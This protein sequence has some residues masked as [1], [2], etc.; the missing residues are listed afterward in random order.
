MGC[1]L[2][3]RLI[4]LWTLYSMVDGSDRYRIFNFNVIS[5]NV[6]HIQSSEFEWKPSFFYEKTFI[7]KKKTKKENC[8][9]TIKIGR[10]SKEM[11]TLNHILH[12]RMYC[13]DT[14]A[15]VFMFNGGSPYGF[16]I[17]PIFKRICM[18]YRHY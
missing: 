18:L 4:R 5:K 9:H 16:T 8:T 14:E 10:K 12:L 1:A 17:H 7:T 2:C 6:D 13:I 15:L 3:T 11:K